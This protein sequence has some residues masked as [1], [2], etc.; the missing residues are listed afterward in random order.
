MHP[1]PNT[2]VFDSD[3]GLEQALVQGIL[4]GQAWFADAATIRRLKEL[5]SPARQSDL[6]GSLRTLESGEFMLNMMW[7]PEDELDY[8]LGLYSGKGMASFKEKLGQFPAGS[9]FRTVTTKAMLEAHQA[10]FAEAERVA[11]ANGQTVEIL[12]SR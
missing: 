11:S 7:W 4:L 5:T 8:T 12:T 10:E 9:H 6:D 1:R 3:I 2:I